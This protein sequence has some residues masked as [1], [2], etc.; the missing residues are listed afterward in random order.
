MLYLRHPDR[1]GYF[2]P[3][4]A[5][6]VAIHWWGR[7]AGQ[8]A[9]EGKLWNTPTMRGPRLSWNLNY[10][11]RIDPVQNDEFSACMP[12]MTALW[13]SAELNPHAWNETHMW[14]PSFPLF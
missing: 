5:S 10:L 14:I 2:E 1:G 3:A 8:K 9:W 13:R 4:H 6:H 12:R 11:S 7:V